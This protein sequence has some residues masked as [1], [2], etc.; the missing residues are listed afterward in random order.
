M[1]IEFDVP[2]S[3]GYKYMSLLAGTILTATPSTKIVAVKFSEGNLFKS[4]DNLIDM[5]LAAKLASLTF[6]VNQYSEGAIMLSA[7]FSGELR[8]SDL[9]KAATGVTVD[10]DIVL[11]KALDDKLYKCT[12]IIYTGC[13]FVDAKEIKGILSKEGISLD[14]FTLISARYSNVS[15]RETTPEALPR[16]DVVTIDV[17]SDT[18]DTREAFLNACDKVTSVIAS[19]KENFDKNTR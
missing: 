9:A 3:M 14:D 12:V 19:I 2:K 18:V 5:N 17:N 1:K 16:T 10:K 13:G 7:T 11:V 15:V 8:S 6:T 4:A